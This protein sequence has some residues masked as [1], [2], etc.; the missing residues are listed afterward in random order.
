MG[1][2]VSDQKGEFVWKYVFA[3]QASEQCRIYEDLAIGKYRDRESENVSP[4][5]KWGDLLMLSRKDLERLAQIVK[6][7]RRLLADFLRE[8]RKVF[9]GGCAPMDEAKSLYTSFKQRNPDV[10]FHLMCY[11]Y[12]KAGCK[13][14]AKYPK[15]KTWNC[16]GEF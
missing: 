11:R 3:E 1:R 7:M 16:Y 9:K 13:H 2:S 4:G 8:Q 5:R 10:L 15:S 12:V 6:P 14:F